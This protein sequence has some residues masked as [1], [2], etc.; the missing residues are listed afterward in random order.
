MAHIF[1]K[2]SDRVLQAY[3]TG[4]DSGNC[5]YINYLEEELLKFRKP[6]DKNKAKEEL[7]CMNCN[8]TGKI[9]NLNNL[10]PVCNGMG[11]YK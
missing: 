7:R 10:C 3:S 8:G 6:I 2:E 4:T 9:L 5:S 1:D 11:F